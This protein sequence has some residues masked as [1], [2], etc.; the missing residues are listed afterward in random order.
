MDRVAY[1]QAHVSFTA[2]CI[3]RIHRWESQV[4]P[5]RQEGA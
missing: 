1:G 5:A 3:A 2:V 4:G